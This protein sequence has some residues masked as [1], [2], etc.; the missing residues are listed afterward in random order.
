MS[1]ML[2]YYLLYPRELEIRARG[3]LLIKFAGERPSLTKNDMHLTWKL[4]DDIVIV[5]CFDCHGRVLSVASC[6]RFPLCVVLKLIRSCKENQMLIKSM[7][8]R[9]MN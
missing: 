8:L 1:T 9:G 3:Y 2:I 7:N 6:L 4:S 5:L